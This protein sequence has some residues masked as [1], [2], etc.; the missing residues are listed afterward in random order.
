VALEKSDFITNLN[1]PEIQTDPHFQYAV[2][3]ELRHWGD[4]DREEQNLEAPY[5]HLLREAALRIP[6][7]TNVT[8][9]LEL[10]RL[11]DAAIL[12][13]TMRSDT[14]V[15][16]KTKDEDLIYTNTKPGSFLHDFVQYARAGNAP[17]AFYFWAG[18]ALLSAACRRKVCYQGAETIYLNMY[19]I[20]GAARAAGKGQAL[21]G[22]LNVLNAVNTKL[23]TEFIL[24]LKKNP[25]SAYDLLDQIITHIPSDIT[26]EAMV[27]LL[28]RRQCFSPD[29]DKKIA[30]AKGNAKRHDATGIL[31][32]DELGTFLGKDSFN[33][34]K[35]PLFLTEIKEADVFNKV[36]KKDMGAHETQGEQLFNTAVTMIACCAPDWLSK[37]IDREMLGGGFTDR[38]TWIYRT[39]DWEAQMER[40]IASGVPKNPL[41]ANKLADWLIKNVLSLKNLEAIAP[42]PAVAARLEHVWQQLVEG[43]KKEF[44]KFGLDDSKNSA[45]RVFQG[46]LQLGCL[47][48]VSDL[49]P[50]RGVFKPITMTV[51]HI[52]LATAIIM[53][54]EA[55]KILEFITESGGCIQR[56][57]LAQKFRGQHGMDNVQDIDT[58]LN[59]MLETEELNVTSQGRTRMYRTKQ[60][61]IAGGCERCR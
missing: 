53:K 23:K 50:E 43:S 5:A 2:L 31:A 9:L 34:S 16:Y 11:G 12:Q 28:H 57:L 7:L 33:A 35:K 37:C 19:I 26:P 18:V 8:D 56:S 55:A 15:K 52:D 20:L 4:Y 10:F 32:L 45:S 14:V 22:M 51:E 41:E 46:I 25:D 58:A 59:N 6:C 54:E 1:M 21:R 36:T 27:T 29:K 38:C 61:S 39:P 49:D 60:H 48:A 13:R 30:Q 40:S 42:T 24:E 47:L 3:R 44:E 17:L